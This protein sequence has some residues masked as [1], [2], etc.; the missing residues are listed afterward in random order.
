MKA[1][2]RQKQTTKASEG[3]LP[4][5]LG[6]KTGR[7]RASKSS[8]QQQEKPIK[9]QKNNNLLA[10]SLLRKV[11]VKFQVTARVAKGPQSVFPTCY[12]P[13]ITNKQPGNV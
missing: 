11:Q 10:G 13:V 6:I 7:P 2:T 1:A 5:S 3:R 12:D 8:E 4:R 9:A